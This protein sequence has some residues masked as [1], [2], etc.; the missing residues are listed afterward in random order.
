MA[1]NAECQALLR[2][3]NRLF[4]FEDHHR[5]RALLEIMSDVYPDEPQV[6]AALATMAR[7]DAEMTQFLARASHINH[8]STIP[9]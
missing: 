7:D 1:T 2:T 3:A 6:W 9:A 4:R 5:A 8:L